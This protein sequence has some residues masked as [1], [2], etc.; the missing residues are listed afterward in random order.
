MRPADETCRVALVTGACSGIGN[1][2][3]TELAGLGYTLVLVS[4]RAPELQAVAADLAARGVATHAVPMDLAR[5]EAASALYEAVRG[6]GLEVDVLVNNA[7]T[8][9]FGE[10]SDADPARIEAMLQLHVVTPSLLARRFG[11]DM[12]DR[13]RGHVL[14]VA[15][16]SAWMPY[17][18]IATYAASKRYLLD[19]AR[20]LRSELSPW[21]VNVTVLAPGATAT[22]FYA[23]DL[24]ARGRRWGVRMDPADVARAGL[25]GMFRRRR[26][27]VPGWMSKL[28]TLVA[29]V[30][31]GWVV[32]RIRVWGPWMPVPRR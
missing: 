29:L 11:R 12:R 19:F 4:H 6:L 26:V 27:V 10:V 16:M 24:A 13:R 21:G 23:P 2:I 8:F 18:S 20:A 30:V 14:F 7:G 1:A 28:A 3:A 32:H 25:R 15:S 5:P 17:P 9:F 31:P 22:G